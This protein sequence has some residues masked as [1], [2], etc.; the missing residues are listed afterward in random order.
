MSKNKEIIR[1]KKIGLINSS[2]KEKYGF[3]DKINNKLDF[4]SGINE[5]IVKAI[6]EHKEEDKFMRDFRLKSFKIFENSKMPNWGPSIKDLDFDSIH[7]FVKAQDNKQKSWDEVPQEIKTT[8]DKL[9]VPNAERK[10]L[11]GVA[12]QYESEVVYQKLK[13][14]WD[15][16]GLIFLDTDTAYKQYPEI[17]KKYFGK[18]I[19]PTDNKFAALNS[20]AWSGGS[21]I[22]VPKGVKVKIP[23]QTYFRINLKN[24]GQFE[25]TLIIADEDSEVHYIEGCT[26]P[27][28]S[29]DSL[30]SAVVEVIVKKNAKVRYTT[31][32]NWS[33]NVYNLVTKRALV[34]ENG[35]MEWI[36]CNLGSKVT[37]KY[38]SLYLVGNNSYGEVLSLALANKGQIIDSGAKAI[39]KGKN[40]KSMIISKSISLN[41]GRSSF[42][43]LVQMS[44]STKD[45]DSKISCEALLL[46]D[47]SRTDTYPT[48]IVSVKNCSIA[49]E[50]SVSKIDSDQ[51][52][53]LNSRGLSNEQASAL[54][55]NGFLEPI[56]KELPME[57]AVELNSL[58]NMSMEGSVG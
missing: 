29:S 32:Q 23:L 39:H 12:T 15:K 36:D 1:N 16:L 5:T 18:L 55:L 35:V 21:F 49:H 20:A 30:H 14:K 24:I 8:F 31:L 2:Y 17:F 44:P 50:A 11:A 41:G 56:S 48:N 38:P 46:D 33:T 28:Y 40:S 54:I 4:G 53:Y 47:I 10:F 37:M 58:I 6:S 13:E 42:R 52:Q 25:R 7:Y 51:M 57:Y 45:S 27:I 43:S 22:Y 19:P 9:G 34:E 26:A 3:N